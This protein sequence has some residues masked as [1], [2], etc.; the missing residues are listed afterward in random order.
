MRRKQGEGHRIE[1]VPGKPI[2]PDGRYIYIGDNMEATTVK[3]KI[4]VQDTVTGEIFSAG[5]SRIR[6]GIVKPPSV[7]RRKIA[8]RYEKSRKYNVG[9]IIPDGGHIRIVAELPAMEYNS[10]GCTQRTRMF[11]FR[12]LETGRLFDGAVFPIINGTVTGKRANKSEV[13]YPGV[14][15]LG[16]ED[17]CGDLNRE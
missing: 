3:E 15:I 5:F 4:I 11:V 12:N 2:D 13:D 7:N 16:E 17:A 8:S 9:D 14:N 1:R 6:E 10:G